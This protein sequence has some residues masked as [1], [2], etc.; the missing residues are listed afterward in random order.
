MSYKN[1]N[2]FIERLRK[3]KELVEIQS[4]GNG[5]DKVVFY[6]NEQMQYTENLA[7]Y[8]GKIRIPTSMTAG[9]TFTVTAKIYDKYG[10]S[11]E[12]KIELR[13]AE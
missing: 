11:G 1:L 12:S 6:M 10:Y 2:E 8:T 13:V 7:P 3:E 4:E 9:T 5:F